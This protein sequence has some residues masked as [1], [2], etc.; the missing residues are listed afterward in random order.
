MLMNPDL[1]LADEAVS[2]LDVSLRTEMMDL[3]LDLQERFNTSYLFI[4]HDLANAWYLTK[5]SDGLIGVMYLGQLVEIGPPD[6][7]INDPQ[8]PYTKAL[9]WATPDFHGNR[10]RGDSPL[11]S[12]DIPDPVNPP[13]GCRFHTRCPEAREACKSET[14]PSYDAAASHLAT[15]FRLDESHEYWNSEPLGD[16]EP[17]RSAGDAGADQTGSADD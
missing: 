3:M 13:S 8:H 1:I 15:C 6:Q 12:I 17:V 10:D 4:S 11:R 16:E 5:K 9:L 2:A 14:P 7:I